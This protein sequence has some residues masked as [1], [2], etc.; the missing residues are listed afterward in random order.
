[1]EKYAG[2]DHSDTSM[3][4]PDVVFR[5]MPT[6]EEYRTPEGVLAMLQG[7]YHGAF[8]AT[9]EIRELVV[10]EGR[11]ALEGTVVGKHT[12]DFAGVPASGKDVRIPLAVF[13]DLADDQITE[14]RIYLEVPVFLAQV[15]G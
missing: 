2:S 11:A 6:G 9:A 8:E 10:G 14:G 15:S 1:M 5:L 7:F 4:S 13:Y 12:G 3:M